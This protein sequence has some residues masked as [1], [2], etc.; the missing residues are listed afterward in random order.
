MY[1]LF[2][3]IFSHSDSTTHTGCR[4]E[5]HMAALIYSQTSGFE[6]IHGLLDRVM[7]LLE[8]N[9]CPIGSADGFYIKSTIHFFSPIFQFGRG[10][11]ISNFK[12][13]RS[14]KKN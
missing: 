4:N 11:F 5:R 6:I 14:K 1:S 10:V 7:E 12:K 8:A 13:Y 3:F 9:R 2:Q